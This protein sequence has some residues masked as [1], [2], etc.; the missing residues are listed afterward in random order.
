[1]SQSAVANRYAVALFELGKEQTNLPQLEEELA[2]VRYVF[3][4]DETLLAFFDNPRISKDDQKQFVNDVFKDASQAV[5]NFLF[6][7]IDKGRIS[8]ISDII[9]SFVEMKNEAEGIA[10]AVVYSVHALSDEEQERIRETFAKKL[11]KNTLRIRNIVDESI[12]G[13][14]KV[15][16]GNQIYDGTV[17]RKLQRIEQSVVSAN[18]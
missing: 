2:S 10:E 12:I 7:L 4:H 15:R 16:V 18:K 5:K 17:A 8:E 3:E 1:M 13:G 9:A 14:L 11:N 6:I